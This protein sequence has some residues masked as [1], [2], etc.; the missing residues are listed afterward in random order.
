[1]RDDPPPQSAEPD[2]SIIVVGAPENAPERQ[3]AVPEPPRPDPPEERA[4]IRVD[5]KSVV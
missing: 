2:R 1:M 4:A 5:R 3:D